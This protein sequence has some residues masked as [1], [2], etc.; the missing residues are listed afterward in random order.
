MSFNISFG[1]CVG[2]RNLTVCRLYSTRDGGSGWLGVVSAVGSG[3]VNPRSIGSVEGGEL[4]VTQVSQQ[5]FHRLKTGN[6]CLQ[7]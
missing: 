2:L 1:E 5:Y 7:H 6:Q 3:G 4:F